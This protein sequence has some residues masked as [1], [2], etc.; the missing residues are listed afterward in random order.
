MLEV[1]LLPAKIQNFQ[2]RACARICA[3]RRVDLAAALAE[4]SICSSLPCKMATQDGLED[5]SVDDICDYLE[6]KGFS[7]AIVEAFRGKVSYTT[8]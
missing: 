7:E 6:Q 5:K 3:A 2:T 1:K 8:L 4:A